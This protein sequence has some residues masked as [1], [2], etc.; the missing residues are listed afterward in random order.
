MIGASR[1]EQDLQQQGY[2]SLSILNEGGQAYVMIANFEVP[3]GS[4]AGRIIDLAIPAPIDYPRVCG[5]SMHVRS[6]PQLVEFGQV[7]GLRNVIASPLGPDWQ[8]WSYAF[9][10]R[11]GNTTGE[12]MSQIHAVFRAN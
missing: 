9:H 6:T 4:F 12:L 11:P 8:Y 10:A 5:A 1:L 7:Q 3:V 2:K